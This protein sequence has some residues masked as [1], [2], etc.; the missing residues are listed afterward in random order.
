VFT[1]LPS[2]ESGFFAKF[3]MVAVLL[4]SGCT[5]SLR[6]RAPGTGGVQGNGSAPAT[7]GRPGAGGATGLGSVSPTTNTVGEGG[8]P[9]TGG[10]VSMGGSG[11]TSSTVP[12]QGGAI[13]TGGEL[14][15]GDAAGGASSS[16]GASNGGTS[17]TD[18]CATLPY[19]SCVANCLQALGA[20][21]LPTCISG[22]WKCP[23][24]YVLASSCP[25][26]ACAVTADACCDRTTGLVTQ[27]PCTSDGY[28]EA[29]PPG[30]SQT[31]QGEA[32]C[33]PQT[34]AIS[35]FKCASLDGQPCSGTALG[36]SDMSG[37]FVNCSC[38]IAHADGAVGS[39]ACTYFIG[40]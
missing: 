23:S 21:G 32:W 9:A 35:G 14:V 25:A 6:A 33:I 1:K 24:G 18:A 34:L 27:N 16:V 7:G 40:P 28:R 37:G 31:Y 3:C 20:F 38:S 15:G 11:R 26:Q 12:W 10:M 29:C 30:S 13:G 39:W 22:A 5:E 4:A 17:G 8:M 19:D 2:V 36:C